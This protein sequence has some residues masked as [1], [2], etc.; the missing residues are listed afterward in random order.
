MSGPPL[1]PFGA[2]LGEGDSRN[3]GREGSVFCNGRPVCLIFR[4]LAIDRVQIDVTSRADSPWDDVELLAVDQ[5]IDDSVDRSA[6]HPFIMRDDSD[7]F[8]S[9]DRRLDLLVTL[10]QR[11]QDHA[12]PPWNSLMKKRTPAQRPKSVSKQGCLSFIGRE[13]RTPKV[14]HFPSK[15]VTLRRGPFLSF[16]RS[17]SL[18]SL[19]RRTG[20]IGSRNSVLKRCQMTVRHPFVKQDPVGILR[21]KDDDESIEHMH[22][23]CAIFH[24]QKSLGGPI[25]I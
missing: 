23:C 16:F 24:S 15:N 3:I 7:G 4:R 5:F 12:I 9:Q 10:D 11:A 13:K 8:P 14:S 2:L 6:G 18:R 17:R 19:L 25:V 22:I 20:M 1:I 21:Q